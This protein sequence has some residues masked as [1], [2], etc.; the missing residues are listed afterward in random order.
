MTVYDCDRTA[1]PPTRG[2][3]GRP[4]N[5]KNL[6][7]LCA[8]C[9]EHTPVPNSERLRSSLTAGR[10]V[11]TIPRLDRSAHKSLPRA[12]AEPQPLFTQRH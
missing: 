2:R 9:G 7:A 4:P 11:A 5:P 1:T 12:V 8:L 6:C 10:A 3:R